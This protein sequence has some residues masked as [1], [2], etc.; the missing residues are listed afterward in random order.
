MCVE[1]E[2][3]P[4]LEKSFSNVLCILVIPYIKQKWLKMN[5]FTCPIYIIQQPTSQRSTV[6][7]SNSYLPCI[8]ASRMYSVW[9]LWIYFFQSRNWRRAAELAEL[10]QPLIKSE[11]DIFLQGGM[12]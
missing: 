4:H 12:K 6:Q 8:I 11:A 3:I 7:T 2:A 1:K 10:V 5:L 9:K